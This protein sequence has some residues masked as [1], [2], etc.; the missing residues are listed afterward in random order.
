AGR[1]ETLDWS[2]YTSDEVVFTPK[3]M[4]REQLL[5]G[6]NWVGRRFY[7]NGSILRRWHRVGY[8]YP[9]RFWW[10]NIANRRY[11]RRFSN[12]TTNNRPDEYNH[13]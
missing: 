6:H 8:M 5:E 12:A 10:L 7:E 9:V 4:T 2:R 1:L 3:N 13:L 11:F